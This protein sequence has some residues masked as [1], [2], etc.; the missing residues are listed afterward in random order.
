MA[1]SDIN[2]F[3]QH[4]LHLDPT[5]K[6]ISL[7]PST[8]TH[9]S[10]TQTAAINAELQQLNLLHRALIS[11]DP[12][13]I[14]PPPLPVNPKRSAQINKLRDSANTAFRKDNYAEAARLYTYAI[15]MAMGRPGWEPVTLTR[16]E[17]AGLYA[18][19]AQAYMSQ[20]AWPEGMLDAK[21][22]VESKPMGNVKAWWRAARCLA[23]MGRW[24]E[25]KNL[26]ER[27]LEIEGK[28]SEGA[29]DLSTLLEEVEAGIKRSST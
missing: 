16:E 28:N 4:A 15:D 26:I 8:T 22:S 12:P 19:R 18:N 25:S 17:L 24:E 13:N 14:P 3:N 7:H 20:Q 10:T 11:L 6:A 21:C 1:T 9:Q 2:I 27:G 23:E 5:S 29:K